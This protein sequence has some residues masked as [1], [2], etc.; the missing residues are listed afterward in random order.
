MC[1]LHITKPTLRTN[2][3]ARI[4]KTMARND[5]HL[6]CKLLHNRVT[7]VIVINS[8]PYL[9]FAVHNHCLTRLPSPVSETG[10]L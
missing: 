1:S 6:P 4:S 5:M 10:E 7:L 9:A 3:A 2:S 8:N